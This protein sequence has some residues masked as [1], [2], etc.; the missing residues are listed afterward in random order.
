MQ[1][2]DVLLGLQVSRSDLT[3]WLTQQE[4][5]VARIARHSLNV[6]VLS[7]EDHLILEEEVW[8]RPPSPALY[9]VAVPAPHPQPCLQHP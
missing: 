6:A 8:R 2:N 4:L 1:G 9:P 3:S 5:L 7:W